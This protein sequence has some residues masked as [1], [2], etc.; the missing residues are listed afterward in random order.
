MEHIPQMAENAAP[1][2]RNSAH[3]RYGKYFHTAVPACSKQELFAVKSKVWQP[4]KQ[5]PTGSLNLGADSSDGRAPVSHT[6]GQ[7]F[8][9]LSAHHVFCYKKRAEAVLVTPSSAL[10]SQTC[11]EVRDG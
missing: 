3:S 9:T 4:D 11:K 5:W 7:G 1:G 2:S 8:E 6:G 10:T